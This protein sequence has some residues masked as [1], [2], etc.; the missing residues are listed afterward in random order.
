[1]A[2]LHLIK[3]SV[4]SESVDSLIQWQSSTRAKGPDGLPRHITRMWPKREA[5]LLEGGSIYW[6]VQGLVQCRQRLVRFDEVIGNDGIRRCAFVL[7]TE[8]I[9]TS[10][11]PKRPFQGWRYLKPEDA[12]ADLPAHRQE[13]DDLPADLSAALAD[14]GVL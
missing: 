4:G 10:S 6:V 14:I 3:L 5:E 13:E 12:P 11:A 1:M 2:K 9:R 7:D 8:V